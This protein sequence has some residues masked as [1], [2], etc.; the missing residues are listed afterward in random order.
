MEDLYKTLGV[1]RGASDDDIRKAFKKKARQY[2]PDLNPGDNEAESRFKA[3]N[4]A[5][6][7][8][9]DADSRKKYD[10][11]G[12]NWKHA[13]QFEAQQQAHRWT[14]RGGRPGP[15]FEFDLFGGLGDL[16]GG[17]RGRSRG[18]AATMTRAQTEVQI[19]LQEA[20]SGTKRMVTLTTGDKD[21]RIEAAIP[22]GVDTG[23]VVRLSLGADQEVLLRVVV[24]S[25][26]RFQRKGNDLFTDVEVPMADAILGGEIEVRTLKG[27]V[28]LKVPAE[29]QNGQRIRLGKQG[30]PKLG[31]PDI[32]GDLYVAIRPVMPKSLS[33]EQRELIRRFNE[34]GSDQR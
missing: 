11:Y 27:K 1:S 12:E 29:S 6:G 30:M 26:G 19:T 13:D 7:V 5:Y 9:S 14:A 3:I 34:L 32:R 28:Q 4:E 24:A 22:P 8:L 2:H 25:N 33:D 10:K 16:L 23:S 18:G 31:T 20:F 17:H 21:R 15:E